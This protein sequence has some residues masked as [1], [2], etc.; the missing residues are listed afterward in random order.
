MKTFRDY[1]IGD[2]VVI[3]NNRA[4]PTGTVAVISELEEPDYDG[5]IT[6]R[7]TL[8]NHQEVWLLDSWYELATINA[9]LDSQ[10]NV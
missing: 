2:I 3:T 10:E 7:V 4:A 1:K 8:P 5:W 6:T 9:V